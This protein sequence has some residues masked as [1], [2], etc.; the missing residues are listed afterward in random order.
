[1]KSS[2]VMNLPFCNFISVNF[3]LRVSSGEACASRDHFL[4]FLVVVVVLVSGVS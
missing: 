4:R 3:F 2:T 1:M